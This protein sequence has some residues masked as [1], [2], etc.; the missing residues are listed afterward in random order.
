MNDAVFLAAAQSSLLLGLIHGVNPCGHSWLVL[1]PF[2]SGERRGRRVFALTAA[3]LGGTLLACLAIGLSLGAVSAVLPP[4]VRF[5][6]DLATNGV[7]VLL[8]LLLVVRPGLL[9]RH[10][11]DHDHEHDHDHGRGHCHAPAHDAR[12]LRW[13]RRGRTAVAGLFL[14]GFVNMVVP[15]PTAAVMYSYALESGSAL[16]A[17]GVFGIYALATAVAVGAVIYAIHKTSDLARRLGS[18][19]L[20]TWLMR[21]IGVLTIVFA[22][23]SL[24][25]DIGL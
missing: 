7:L 4:Q 3:F 11:H 5:W 20:E 9:H 1:A 19:N 14:I 24:Y 10:D 2:V 8:G 17:A 18:G 25:V 12:A 16:R 13:L 21:S 23:Y 15:C 22:S 6:T